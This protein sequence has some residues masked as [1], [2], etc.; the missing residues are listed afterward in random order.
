MKGVVVIDTN[1]LVLLVVG[2]A[3]R[4][5]IQKHKRLS[6]YT[7]EDFDLLGLILSEFSE[8]VFL[9]HILAEVSNIARQ[10]DFPAKRQVQVAFRVLVTT[11]VEFPIQS[12]SG[13]Q[14]EEFGRVGL[15]DAV[16]LHFLALNANG[17]NPTLLT[18][19]TELAN[20]AQSLGY[21]V[22]DYRREFLS[23]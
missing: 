7:P 6:G 10:I 1:L 3:S 17:I 19:D 4:N 5:Y 23:N 15:T 20:L 11:C 18:S 2:S 16:I 21:S 12:I 8:I 13:V 22:I 9:P 14:R